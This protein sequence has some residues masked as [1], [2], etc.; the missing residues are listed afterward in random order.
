MAWPT[1]DGATLFLV[2]LL[3]PLRLLGLGSRLLRG[4]SDRFR[5]LGVRSV[6]L[7]AFVSIRLTAIFALS[8]I[9]PSERG[10]LISELEDLRLKASHLGWP[11]P[12]QIAH[13]F[14]RLLFIYLLPVSLFCVISDMPCWDSILTWKSNFVRGFPV[15]FLYFFPPILQKA[16]ISRSQLIFSHNTAYRPENGGIM[17]AYINPNQESEFHLQMIEVCQQPTWFPKPPTL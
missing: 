16:S 7:F 5:S 6:V 15:Y 12:G 10:A 1:L 8:D 3:L 9:P 11:F 13:L 4:G 14:S 17:L 2:A